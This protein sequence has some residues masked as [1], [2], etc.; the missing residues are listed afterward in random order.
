LPNNL[1]Y[2]KNERDLNDLC[3]SEKRWMAI[4]FLSGTLGVGSGLL[5]LTLSG[6]TWFGFSDYAAGFGHL[7]NWM[8]A[9]F[10]P[11]MILASHALD[12]AGQ[13]RK[14]I[15]IAHAKKHGLKDADC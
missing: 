8:I 3:R 10:I 6:L 12:K 13:A 2:G 4:V 9:V 14:A 15:R 1:Y 11:M 7:G 5:G